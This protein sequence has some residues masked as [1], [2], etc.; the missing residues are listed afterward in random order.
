MP[1]QQS[2]H[3]IVL[4]WSLRFSILQSGLRKYMGFHWILLQV[5]YQRSGSYVPEIIIISV[6]GSGP[7]HVWFGDKVMDKQLDTSYKSMT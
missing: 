6:R 2:C 1:P 7:L 3:M 4:K 5:K